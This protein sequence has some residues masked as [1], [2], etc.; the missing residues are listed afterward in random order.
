MNNNKNKKL[1]NKLSKDLDE[2]T[3]KLDE[4][5]K[6][7]QLSR[8]KNRIRKI[9]YLKP[10]IIDRKDGLD[11]R[12]SSTNHSNSDID[13][14]ERLKLSIRAIDEL[15]PQYWEEMQKVRLSNRIKNLNPFNVLK[16]ILRLSYIST[17]YLKIKYEIHSV[18]KYFLLKKKEKFIC[19]FVK[20]TLNHSLSFDLP[21]VTIVILNRNGFDHLKNLFKNFKKNTIY[22]NYEIIVVD[23]NSCDKSVHFLNLQKDLP[24]R[25]IRNTQNKS[26]SKSNNETVKL[27]KG[28][29]LVFLNN[30][31]IPL[32]GWLNE[33]VKTYYG[34]PDA[35][36]VGSKLIY[37]RRYRN[38]H[39]LK[40]QHNGIGFRMEGGFIRPINLDNQMD[41]NEL[42]FSTDVNYPS[43]TAACALISKRDFLEVNMFDEKYD[44]GY[45]DVDLGLKLVCKKKKNYVAC[46]SIL[47]HNEL[48]TQNKQDGVA[49]DK[50]RLNNKSHFNEKWYR[51]LLDEIWFDKLNGQNAYHSEF[52]CLTI[53]FIVTETGDQT[54]AGDYFTALELAEELSMLGY[55]IKYYTQK[56]NNWY[57][58]DSELDVLIVL[59][60]RYNLDL[61][62][63][64][65]K[66]LIKIAWIRNW[67][68]D[69][70]QA[71]W[72][73]KFDI[74]LSS[75][76]EACDN[77]E[78]SVRKKAYYFPLATKRQSLNLTHQKDEK[79]LCDYC[80]T[81]SYWNDPREIMDFLNPN[82]LPEYTFNLYGK[83][84]ELVEKFKQYSKAF[85][86]YNEM[87]KV[88]ANTKLLIDDANRATNPW[89]SVNSRVFD[90]LMN[91]VL[92]LTNGEKGS[93]DVFDG[94]LP[95]Y[96]NSD[97][98]ESLIKYYL[99]NEKERLIL[100][101]EL[102]EIV[103]KSH[104][105]D[106]RAFHLKQILSTYYSK[107]IVIK[108]PIPVKEDAHEWGDYHFALALKKE[109]EKLE[110]R[111]K[112]DFLNEWYDEGSFSFKNVLVLRGLTK[113][114]TSKAQNNIMWNISHPDK[115]S[116]VE[117]KSYNHVFVASYY[118]TRY[119]NENGLSNASV[120]MQ[121]TDIDLFKIPN[122]NQKIETEVLFVGNSRG[123]FRKVIADLLPSEFNI[124]IY[125]KGWHGIID[126][127]YIKG[128][129]IKNDEL[130][131]YYGGAK[132]VLNDH[133][134][135]MRELGFMSNRLF[136][137]M[138]CNATVI[139]DHVEGID[140]VFGDK[141]LTYDNRE[142]LLSKINS[143][144]SM[145]EYDNR[146]GRQVILNLH[147]FANRA[148]KIVEQM[149]LINRCR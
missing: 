32:F 23:N 146:N 70:Y 64:D 124:S 80:F 44:Y 26:F 99:S 77:I 22:P 41:F 147:T 19:D 38:P 132:V 12:I 35:G 71:R 45:E 131:K 69:F 112:I 4:Y 148:N 5:W 108:V 107:S 134:E 104:T 111:T 75:S 48:G 66:N 65:N 29:F 39:S 57:N 143:I 53:G 141:V 126:N 120:L 51:K 37:P 15:L 17:F 135:D 121:C 11:S 9:L 96:K 27:A 40:V 52:P 79:F 24:L 102:R 61:I 128:E 14:I 115:V 105:Y 110:F 86:N 8:L 92:V 100:T 94:K 83:N 93:Y 95:V 68:D 85:V 137:A 42:D 145:K 139:S 90:A 59:L 127:K 49:L 109:F 31:V 47:F 20:N 140:N 136:D 84:W 67:F 16:N 123:V 62:N 117:Y 28:D 138:A 122:E 2:K 114:I 144:F 130:F 125:G 63:C 119:L 89:G 10:I 88:Y 76:K 46:K 78:N 91:G 33:L 60:H 118:W 82:Q 97:Q 73:D 56:S 87:S 98:L 81:G 113:Y 116:L 1:K 74:I 129:H 54:S 55:K 34:H 6:H 18:I 36:L 72:F 149:K 106:K 43:V 30:D 101:N 13:E 7:I 142:D 21:L 25:I 133:W 50:R 58:L 3:S 103:K